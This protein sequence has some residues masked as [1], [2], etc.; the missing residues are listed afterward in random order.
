[1]SDMPFFQAI[2]NFGTSWSKNYDLLENA[3][4]KNITGSPVIISQLPTGVYNIDGTWSL[5]VDDECR[6]T[7]KDD[8][9]YISNENG[10]CKLTRITAGSIDIF[11]VPK[12]GSASDIVREDVPTASG[13]VE[14]LVADF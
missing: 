7:P 9:F 13:I 4:V 12:N 2:G 6:S 10:E 14:D 3:P 8:L 11:N 5:T 1:M